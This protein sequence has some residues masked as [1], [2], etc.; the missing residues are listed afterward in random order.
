VNLKV[1]EA[2]LPIAAAGV[3]DERTFMEGFLKN[4][5]DNPDALYSQYLGYVHA[6]TNLSVHDKESNVFSRFVGGLRNL[7]PFVD[8]QT[9]HQDLNDAL[10]AYP[11]T[12]EA[13]RLLSRSTVVRDSMQ[14]DIAESEANT[15]P[16]TVLGIPTGRD[17]TDIAT[18]PKYSPPLSVMT[19]ELMHSY[20]DEKG[21]PR[22][23][24]HFQRGWEEVKKDNPL[25][26]VIDQFIA[27][28]PDYSDEMN[29]NDIAQERYAYLAQ[30]L[31]GLGLQAFP[32]ELQSDYAPVFRNGTTGR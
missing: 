13:Q 31:G 17:R 6:P 26:S 8:S 24:A 23:R 9:G 32:H 3:F 4:K 7:V 15:D 25:L 30:A 29:E 12:P 11:F 5:R 16:E 19:H 27:S 14:K 20:L 22:G 10:K 2:R 18:H 21:Y 28:S 1:K